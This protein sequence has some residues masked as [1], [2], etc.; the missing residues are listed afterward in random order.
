MKAR[1]KSEDTRGKGED[2]A[3]FRLMTRPVAGKDRSQVLRKIWIG[4][5]ECEVLL[6]NLDKGEGAAAA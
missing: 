6:L 4:V 1:G 5:A 2:T 3:E